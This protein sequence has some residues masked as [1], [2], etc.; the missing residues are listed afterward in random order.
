M[1]DHQD[2]YGFKDRN[3]PQF[4]KEQLQG[5]GQNKIADNPSTWVVCFIP[6]STRQKHIR[7]YNALVS[8]LRANLGCEI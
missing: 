7:R 3:C 4:V 5:R 6:A 2:A 8:Y 1:Q